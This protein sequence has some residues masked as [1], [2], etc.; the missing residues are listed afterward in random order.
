MW[1]CGP[2]SRLH[3]AV[4]GEVQSRRLT[5]KHDNCA[6]VSVTGL[7]AD[8]NYGVSSW[9]T[10][11]A[12]PGPTP[13]AIRR[14]RTAPP[15][16]Q[17][18]RVHFGFGGDVAGQNVCRHAREG[19]V[20][21][22]KIA[23]RPLDFFIG[24]GDMIYADERCHSRSLYGEP[25]VDAGFEPSNRLVDFWAHWHYARADPHLTTLLQRRPY[26][27]V[28]DDHEVINDVDRTS[29]ALPVGLRAF[30]HQNPVPDSLHRRLRY[31]RHVELIVLDTRQHRDAKGAEDRGDK[32]MLGET[33]RQWLL[34]ALASDAT[35]KI[36]VSS[37]PLSIPTGWPA[38]DGRDGWAN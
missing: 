25:Q 6:T 34:D 1:A 27:A 24:L 38:S 36:I 31:G 10:D 33:Q 2:G 14:I 15:A 21:I 17:T 32:S 37:V 7:R 9:T 4:N 23:R 35:W 13:T 19:F 11:G 18:A 30:R 26:V 29:P 20:L 16:G 8:A 22:E 3:V 28:W 5:P 12:A